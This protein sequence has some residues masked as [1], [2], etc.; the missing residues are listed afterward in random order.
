MN[1]AIKNK[2]LTWLVVLLLIGNVTSIVLFWMNRNTQLPASKATPTEFLIKEL[3]FDIKQQE[4]LELLVARHKEQVPPLRRNIR[5]SKEALFDLLKVYN[6]S[7]SAKTAALKAV[8]VNTEALDSVTFTHFQKIRELCTPEQQ[9][10]FDQII[11]QV[12]AMKAQSRP[13]DGPGP[14]RN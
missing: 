8:S 3:K 4:Q 13:G 5:A 11:H 10:K 1:T 9:N 14:G 6:L 12:T 7:D 2:I